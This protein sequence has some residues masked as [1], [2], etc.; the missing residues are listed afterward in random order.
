MIDISTVINA[1]KKHG[2]MGV[3]AVMLYTYHLR[4]EKVEG[5][6]H[7]CYTE[8]VALVVEIDQQPIQWEA[9]LPK[10]LKIEKEV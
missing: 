3:L 9:V 1:V 10:E 8:K 5:Y 4:L 2:A 6:L 7:E